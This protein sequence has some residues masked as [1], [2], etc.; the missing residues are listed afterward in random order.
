MHTFDIVNILQMDEVVGLLTVAHYTRETAMLIQPPL[1]LLLVL[2]Q[3]L[4]D[5]VMMN[6]PQF[7]QPLVTTAQ[8]DI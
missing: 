8:V 4:G 5:Q 2:A 3:D 1:L 7:L 6:L